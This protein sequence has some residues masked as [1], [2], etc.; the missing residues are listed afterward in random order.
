MGRNARCDSWSKASS[1]AGLCWATEEDVRA[2]VKL[3]LE[4]VINAAGIERIVVVSDKQVFA[5]RPDLW[6]IA[7]KATGEPV[8]AVFPCFRRDV[9]RFSSL[10]G[11][12]FRCASRIRRD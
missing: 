8:S 3:I 10:F 2:V 5:L 11:H 1:A 7:D 12:C 9:L 4:D 6:V